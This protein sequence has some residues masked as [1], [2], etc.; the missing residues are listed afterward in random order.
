MLCKTKPIRYYWQ[1]QATTIAYINV[2]V[3]LDPVS[4]WFTSE[5]MQR[6]QQAIC[7]LYIELVLK[8]HRSR[9]Q[10]QF[11]V[12]TKK[13]YVN[14][15]TI[16]RLFLRFYCNCTIQSFYQIFEICSV[17]FTFRLGFIFY[18]FFCSLLEK[19]VSKSHFLST[20]VK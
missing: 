3:C 15:H 18:N 9:S 2:I 11:Y 13:K 10:F 7:V 17:F 6:L 8:M 20:S 19:Q 4:I 1:C 16:K 14:L 12:K 5:K